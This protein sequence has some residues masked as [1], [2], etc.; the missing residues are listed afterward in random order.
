MNILTFKYKGKPLIEKIKNYRD[1]V[2]REQYLIVMNR[3]S[4]EIFTEIK[5][6]T[7]NK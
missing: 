5:L 3:V 4:G 6:T 7:D 1:A 2:A